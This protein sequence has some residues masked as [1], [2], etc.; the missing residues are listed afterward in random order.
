MITS[1]SAANAER[2][3]RERHIRID[4]IRPFL[5]SLLGAPHKTSSISECMEIGGCGIFR[6]RVSVIVVEVYPS[7]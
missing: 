1:G 2:N 4:S 5:I 3:R 7:R 6:S